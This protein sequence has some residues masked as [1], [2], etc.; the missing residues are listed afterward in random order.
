MPR[1]KNILFSAQDMDVGFT[2]NMSS[3]VAKISAKKKKKK[4]SLS[5]KTKSKDNME[6][7]YAQMFSS[8]FHGVFFVP[9]TNTFRV[10]SVLT[11][12]THQNLKTCSFQ[13]TEKI[14][15]VTHWFT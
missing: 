7:F 3:P 4:R 11:Y 2:L 8:A 1:I 14:D 13:D 15:S 12:K 10:H 6:K 5:G 9:F